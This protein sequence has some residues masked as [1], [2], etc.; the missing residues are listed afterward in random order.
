[1]SAPVSALVRILLLAPF[2]LSAEGV[3]SKPLLTTTTSWN[4]APLQV[5]A[6][7][8]PEI[9]TLIVEIPP[10]ASTAWHKHPVNNFAYILEGRLRVELEDKTFRDFQ[11][12]DAFAE[13]VDTWHRGTNTGTTPLKILV[14]YTG[15]TGVPVSISR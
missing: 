12:G 1:M 5:K 2:L 9:Q 6:T 3:T 14:V 13:V 11:T 15:E 10:G 4:G 7:A 8:R